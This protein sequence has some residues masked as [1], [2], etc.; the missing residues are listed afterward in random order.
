MIYTTSIALAQMGGCTI[1]GRL[2]SD[3][4]KVLS[5]HVP[6]VLWQSLAYESDSD[7]PTFNR[8]QGPR[9]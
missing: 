7:S 2:H 5:I 4:A 6:M 3:I 8:G 9:S 1:P